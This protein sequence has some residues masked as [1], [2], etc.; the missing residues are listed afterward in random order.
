V[1]IGGRVEGIPVHRLN[2]HLGP[3]PPCGLR[4]ARAMRRVKN[5]PTEL[6]DN[7]LPEHTRNPGEYF[8]C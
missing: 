2:P 1:A 3:R 4:L 8:I 6:R 5:P 7:P